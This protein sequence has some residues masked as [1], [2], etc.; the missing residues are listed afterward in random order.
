MIMECELC[1]RE[2][3]KGDESE[4]HLVP[5]SRGGAKGPKATFHPVCHKQIHALFSESDLEVFYNSVSKLRGHRDV[6]R[7]VKWVRKKP[8]GF[9]IKTRIRR[10]RR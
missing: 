9:N 3:L 6:K 4:H 5:K 10:K 2:I 7:F 1:D 8:N